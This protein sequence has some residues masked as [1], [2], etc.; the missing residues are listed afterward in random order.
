MRAVAWRT[1][2]STRDAADGVGAW[3]RHMQ[4]VDVRGDATVRT[5][6]ADESALIILGGTFDLSAGSGSWAQR[7]LRA[8]PFDGRPCALYLPP[9]TPLRAVG[10]GEL[11]IVACRRP[12]LPPATDAPPQMRPLLALSGSGKAY[13]TRTGTWELLE[14]FPSAPEAVLPRAI[15]RV[16]LDGTMVERIFAS[17]FKALALRVDEAVITAGSTFTPRPDASAIP[18]D[19]DLAVFLR[20]PGGAKV[21]A[22]DATHTVDGDAVFV[23]NATSTV[24][25]TAGRLA[26]Y[27][28]CAWAWPKACDP[29]A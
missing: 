2:G 10:T 25:I 5:P 11:L 9:D 7:G 20:A 18:V 13:D 8:T 21:H 23:T 29:K 4:L 22:D 1:E 24:R 6:K 17:A 3:F 15:A 26:A 27:A 16:D 14:R 28:V 19:A 12:E